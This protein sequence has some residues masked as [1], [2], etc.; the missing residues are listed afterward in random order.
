MQSEQLEEQN[1]TI[2][3][4][5]VLRGNMTLGDMNAASLPSIFIQTEGRNIFEAVTDNMNKQISPMGVFLLANP[6]IRSV[7][8]ITS[9]HVKSGEVTYSDEDEAETPTGM[10]TI[11]GGHTLLVSSQHE[12]LVITALRPQQV[13]VYSATGQLLA[14]QWLTEEMHLF[15][16]QGMY[17][18]R[19]EKDEAKVLVQ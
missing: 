16:P 5:G 1:G 3:N 4:Q 2:Q 11:A 17:L 6:D 10:P 19:G 8:K 13:Y 12:E 9:I 7:A 15:V 18:V 14:S